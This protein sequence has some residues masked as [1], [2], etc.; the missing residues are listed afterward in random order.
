MASLPNTAVLFKPHITQN[1]QL[2]LRAILARARILGAGPDSRSLTE[3][4]LLHDSAYA[5]SMGDAAARWAQN[6]TSTA[7]KPIRIPGA[8]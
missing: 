6:R 1:P 3:P 2:D 8:P 5:M 4:A 7:Q